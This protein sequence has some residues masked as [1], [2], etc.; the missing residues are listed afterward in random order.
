MSSLAPISRIVARRVVAGC[1]LLL[2]VS[3]FIFAT[4]EL[5]PGDA[6]R[7][8]LGKEAATQRLGV[9]QQ[10]LGLDRPAPERYATWIADA[11]R[12]DLG[13]SVVSQ[14]P[15]ADIIGGRIENTLILAAATAFV[16]V[17]F[18]L[19]LGIAMGVREGSTTDNVFSSGVV[20]AHAVPEFV[21]AVLLA[22]V[23]GIWLRVLP[24][25]SLI[26]LGGTAL[27]RPAILVLPV[28]TLAVPTV[29]WGARLTRAAV[30]DA[31]RL[32]HVEAARLAGIPERQVL[33]RHLLPTA[34]PAIAQVF[35]RLTGVLLAGTVVVETV[36]NYPGLGWTLVLA[37]GSRDVALVQ[38]IALLLAAVQ[39]GA[40]IIADVLGVLAVPRL[41][42]P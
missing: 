39:I 2:I 4:T 13:T 25:V 11:V 27:D 12:G 28:A 33:W 3:L 6:A 17:P 19:L 7:V 38:G 36:F 21:T 23:F 35:A 15:V 9:V 18:V 40:Y 34:V 26:P 41:R 37:V 32:T 5:L 14:R 1:G 20:I 31:S 10:Q 42:V 24:P 22:A 29:A 8:L 30:A 16:V